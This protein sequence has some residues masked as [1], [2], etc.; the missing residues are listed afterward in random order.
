MDNCKLMNI[1]MPHVFMRIM[2]CALLVCLANQQMIYSQANFKKLSAKERRE[3]FVLLFNGKDLDGWTGETGGAEQHNYYVEDGKIICPK[4]G[5]RLVTKEQ[6]KNF[7]LRLEYKLEP[8]GNNGIGLHAP[9]NTWGTEVQ[10][11]DDT[12]DEWKGI[13]DSEYNGSIYGRAAA[14][15]GHLKPV[16]QWNY[17]EITADGPRTTVNL[18]GAK[19]LDC[20][21]KMKSETAGYIKLLGHSSR[22]EFRNL[23]IKVLK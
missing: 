17:M 21:G 6:Y 14:E 5:I 10:I 16:G 15:R 18:N 4:K 9:M 22:V 2:L 11:L 19:I 12:S 3:G 7:V 13:K 20:T 1:I 8:G 23:R